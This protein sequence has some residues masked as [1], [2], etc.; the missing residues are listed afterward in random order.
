V[1][2]TLPALVALA[3]G[4]LLLTG[5]LFRHLGSP[6]LG[7]EEGRVA[8]AAV[9]SAP[10]AAGDE[11]ARI[12]ARFATPFIGWARSGATPA[13]QASRARLA[14]TLAGFAG[15]LLMGAGVG[16]AL[17]EDRRRR[18]YFAALFALLSATSVSLAIQLR[19]VGPG[20]L[21]V[22]VLA[23]VLA[24]HVRHLTPARVPFVPY[25]LGQGALLT[26]LLALAPTLWV[27]AAGA[28]VFE[29]ALATPRGE[30][31]APIL[32]M[33]AA[34]GLS[35]LAAGPWIVWPDL[36]LGGAG[37]R[38]AAIGLHLLRQELL[39]PAA[40]ARL[41]VLADR[42]R[43]V[44]IRAE[45]GVARRSGSLAF[46]IAVATAAIAA[47]DPAA[48]ERLL[49]GAGPLLAL[50]FLLDGYIL[51]RGLPRL[52]PPGAR[53]VAR[54]GIA[55]ALV[56]LVGASLIAR[57]STLELRA[58]ALLE[59]V[60][61][62]VDFVLAHVEASFDAPGRVHVET[63]YESEAIRFHLGGEAGEGP[64]VF[65]PRAQLTFDAEAERARRRASGLGETPLPVRDVP[66]GGACL[67]A[68]GTDCAP[69]LFETP[70]AV[71][72][73]PDSVR[74]F[75]RGGPVLASRASACEDPVEED[76]AWASTTWPWRRATSTHRTPS[77][78]RRRASSS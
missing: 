69:H 29:Q 36:V 23:S 24:L 10:E 5:S 33:L 56:L 17:G 41:F 39:A 2:R 58:R 54:A 13:S 53:R 73:A 25:V 30:R 14:F 26:G 16:A 52:A 20:A 51:I 59:R 6:A 11:P 45:I 38:A 18:V 48:D 1:T 63:N 27:A 64:S 15:L 55:T 50:A 62:P 31:K 21:V 78:A 40:V 77:T 49:V 22:A 8:M 3:L 74:V 42:G 67:A 65:V 12:A 43:R 66:T 44:R 34:F 70:A 46:G 72:G 9:R 57:A 60:R 68:W 32:R 61:G 71:E 76:L 35:L 4:L 37:E 75:A 7:H 28:C 47:L 19:D